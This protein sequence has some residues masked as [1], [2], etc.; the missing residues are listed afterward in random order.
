MVL[1]ACSLVPTSGPTPPELPT[2]RPTRPSQTAGSTSL[3]STLAGTRAPTVTRTEK[4]VLTA[5]ATPRPG[6]SASSVPRNTEVQTSQIERVLD[7]DTIDVRIGDEM[8]RVRYIG[9]DTPE[10]G[11]PF[12]GDAT[13]Q[14]RELVQA[15]TVTLVKDVSETDRHGRLLRS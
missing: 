4:R 7:G 13:E 6:E 11:N 8:Y 10:V 12:P 14:N 1:Q 3:S 2:P 15:Q 5:H 9:V